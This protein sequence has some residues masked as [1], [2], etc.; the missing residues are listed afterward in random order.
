MVALEVGERGRD[1]LIRGAHPRPRGG[2]IGPDD[3]VEL[4]ARRT[5]RER[6]HGD[7][8]APELAQS[9]E[10]PAADAIVASAIACLD[11]AGQIWTRTDGA[12]D[13]ADLDDTAV[14]AVR[15]HNG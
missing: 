9:Q 7:P 8:R 15:L 3:G 2:V 1:D 4:G 14:R 10:D 11:I 13:L 6:E 5:G 12:A